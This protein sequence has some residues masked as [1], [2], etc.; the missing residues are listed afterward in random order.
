MQLLRDGRDTTTVATAARIVATELSIH[1]S[2]VSEVVNLAM[3]AQDDGD[4]VLQ[5]LKDYCDER[6]GQDAGGTAGKSEILP[7]DGT[8]R[9][10]RPTQ[11]ATRPSTARWAT[12]RP[13]RGRGG[14]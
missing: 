5:D 11:T 9:P 1:H 6:T 3:E 13:L 14:G 4:D 12:R 10:A 8:W 7:E 2:V